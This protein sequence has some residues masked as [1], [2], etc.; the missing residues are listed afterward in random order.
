VLLPWEA[1]AEREN[2]AVL[3]LS[4]WNK[5][6]SGLALS[7]TIAVEIQSVC[8]DGGSAPEN[9]DM[10]DGAVCATWRNGDIWKRN[11]EAL[12]DRSILPLNCKPGSKEERDL[13]KASPQLIRIHPDDVSASIDA[14]LDLGI[15][16]SLLQSEPCIFA[17]PREYICEGALNFLSNM[18]MLRSKDVALSLCK[19]TPNLFLAS[20]EGYM[21]ERSVRKALGA[22]SDAVYSA[23]KSV[24]ADVSDRIRAQRRKRGT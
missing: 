6:D 22:A 2:A 8:D 16:I 7:D 4:N 17:Y 23:S 15:P 12:V 24:A 14:A 5:A 9:V 10:K 11:R 20:I 3:D 1:A 21:Q 18:M 13:L 19:S